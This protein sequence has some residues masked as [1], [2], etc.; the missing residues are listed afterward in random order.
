MTPPSPSTLSLRPVTTWFCDAYASWQKGGVENANGRLRRWLP[1]QIDIDK[2]SRTNSDSSSPPISRRE[3]ASVSVAI[4]GDPQIS[5]QRRANP[6]FIDPFTSLRESSEPIRFEAVGLK[7][8]QRKRKA[9]V[10]ADQRGRILRTAYLPAIRRCRAVSSI[11]SRDRRRQN[12]DRRRIA[13]AQINSQ[14][15]ADLRS[16]SPRLNSR[17]RCIGRMRTSHATALNRSKRSAS[18]SRSGRSL[19]RPGRWMVP[20]FSRFRASSIGPSF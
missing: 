5:W 10:D 7:I 17:C 14:A 8:T 18:R 13:L 20:P 19:T 2:V 15:L 3:N 9:V 4:P 1:R 6:V 16:A 11:S 12:L